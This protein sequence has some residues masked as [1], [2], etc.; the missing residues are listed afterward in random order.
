MPQAYFA[1]Q[2][3]LQEPQ[4]HSFSQNKRPGVNR[5]FC[6][7]ELIKPGERALPEDPLGLLRFRTQ[8]ADPVPGS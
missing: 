7:N 2:I 3:E 5:V 1:V 4:I 8:L 6:F